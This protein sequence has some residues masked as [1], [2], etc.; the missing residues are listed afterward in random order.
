[1]DPIG[2]ISKTFNFKLGNFNIAPTYWQAG[3]II[4]LLFLLVFTLARMR[5]LY[6]NWS[7]GK[8][9]ISFLF[10]GFLLALIFE[11]F[12]II[13]GRTLLTEILGW[14]NAPKPISTALDRGREKLVDVLGVTEEIPE[15]VASEIPTYQSI[16][17][18][19]ENLTSHDKE[20]VRSFVCEP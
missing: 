11:G 10:W 19:F 2:F 9:S 7:L 3:I 15:S 12:L 5:Y 8:N 4:A 16:I 20:A 13:S 17:S 1:M 6:V 18:D 14:K